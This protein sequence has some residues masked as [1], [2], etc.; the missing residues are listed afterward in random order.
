LLSEEAAGKSQN[1][2]SP[3]PRSAGEIPLNPGEGA[4][5]DV[6]DRYFSRNK[7]S[8]AAVADVVLRLHQAKKTEQVIACIEAALIHGHSQPWMYTVLAL[9]MEKAGR[10]KAEVERVL[11]STVDYSAVNLSNMLFS[12]AFLTRF[13][14]KERALQLYR[15]ASMV[16]PTRLEPYVLGLKLARDAKDA[17]GILWAATGI[18]TRAW[19]RDHETLHRQAEEAAG[20]LEAA[21]R[22]EGRNDEAD[23]LAAALQQ[24]RQRDLMIDLSWSGRAD[25]DLVVEEPGGTVC[26]ADS[27]RTTGGGIFVHDGLGAD[28]KDSFDRYVCPIGRPGEY[29]II[30]RHVWGEVVGKRAVVRVV[31]YQ[32]S[33]QQTEDEIVVP[34]SAKDS[35]VRVSLQHGRLKEG[36]GLLL[37]LESLQ[38]DR[39]I[40]GPQ[41]LLQVF[42]QAGGAPVGGAQIA[43]GGARPFVTG[44]QPVVGAGGSVGYQPVVTLLSEGVA[45]S[46]LAVVSGDRR[47]VRMSLAPSLSAITD[48]FTFSFINGGSQP[49][50]TAP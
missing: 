17:D 47:Y 23:R 16:D 25:L 1:A 6:W 40:R 13:G 9:E 26:A 21:L 33:S 11:L 30:V 12:A 2:A 3:Q 45:M 19:T 22:T 41:Q 10:P 20:D 37:P 32:G 36:A 7:P 29:R 31:R 48:V 27:Q 18:L 34:L 24:A 49:G 14:M 15:Q 43:A 8:A 50:T 46:A 5:A 28:S 44:V 4:P 39:R 42:A 38:T 35:I